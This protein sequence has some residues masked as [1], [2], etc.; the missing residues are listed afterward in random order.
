MAADPADL[1]IEA[2]RAVV[3]GVERPCAVAVRDGR[4]VAVEA[5]DARLDA[6]ERVVLDADVVLLPGLVDTH[7]HVNEPGRTEWEGFA[8]ATRAAAAGGVT[9]ILDMPLNSVP[10]TTDVAALEAK[11]AAAE[12]ACF[13]DVG[14]WGGAVPDNGHAL[15]DLWQAGVFGFKA[16]LVDSGVP[17]FPALTEDGLHHAAEAIAAFGGLLLV[18]AEDPSSLTE[19]PADADCADLARSRPDSAEVAAMRAVVRASRATGCRVHVVHLAAG[20]A[21]LLVQAAHDTGVPISA[22][23][24]PHYLTFAVEEIPAHDTAFKC[25]PPIRDAANRERLWAGLESGILGMVVTDHSPSPAELKEGGI[26]TA[27]GGV[28]SLQLGLAATWTA[29]RDRGHS[30]A[31]VA[32]WMAS[33]P[34]D[35]AGLGRKGRIAVGSDAD[36]CVFAPEETFTVDPER[37]QHRH[38]VTPYAGRSLSGVVRQTWLAG[39]PVDLEDA[40]R[41]RLLRRRGPA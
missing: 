17:E 28:S 25:C 24:C 38:P 12:G 40:P 21:V 41:G 23:T 31:D 26:A 34:A 9:T 4:V 22:E 13:V 32:R 37:L 1:V 18:H 29:A 5:R 11:R 3:D 33:G 10:P 8:H 15:H 19:L 14:F 36:L 35:R 20:S 39:R 30:V 2:P 7:V 6:V 27:W 16:F